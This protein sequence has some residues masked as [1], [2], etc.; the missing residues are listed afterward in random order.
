MR[1]LCGQLS[2][3]VPRW[4]SRREN[5]FSQAAAGNLDKLLASPSLWMCV[6]CYACSKRCPR[7]IELTEGL[8]PALRDAAMQQGFQPPA[9]LQETFQNVLK[10][11]NVLGKSPRQRL[12]WA[13]NLDVRVLDLS[14]EA[15]AGRRAVAGGLLPVVLSRNQVVARAFARI[16]TELG[17]TWGILGTKEKAV[18]ECDRM[19][20]EEGLFETLV[21]EN[22]KLFDK[23]DFGKLV[24]LDPH[25]YRALQSFYPRF[26]HWYPVQH[27]TM[28]L[29]EYL[30]QLRP[31]MVK[32]V[33]AVVTYHDNCCVGRRCGCY[34][35]PRSL[36]GLIPGVK[37]VEMARNRDD[38]LCC[39]G[40][41]GGMWL[42]AHIVAHGGQ[43][44][45]DQRIRQA[46][47]SG[48]DTLAVSCPY[49]LSRFEDAAKVTGLEGQI[50]V[51]D[52]IE[53]LAE[54]MDLGE[55][56]HFMNIVV[57]VRQ[58]PDLIEP[59]EVAP[60]GTELDLGAA[61]FILNESDDHALEQALLLKEA[62]GG[63]VTVVALDFGEVDNTL[64]TAA[65][66]GADRIVKIV[67]DGETPS[68]PRSRGG[69][70]AE[71]IKPL[72]ADLV[73]VGVQAH[74]EL[75]GGLSPF[76]AV[77]LG[78]PYVGVIRGVKAGPEAGTVIA[79]KEFPG[80]VMARM[81]VKL[82]AVLGILARISPRVT[83]R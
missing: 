37:L 58:V 62:H 46:A 71:A 14:R 1:P 34:D 38:S 25:A 20:G 49:E 3:W 52:I 77:A 66:K 19:F 13:K 29:A 60:S 76:L 68:P 11:G 35:P 78:L 61:S 33:E 22:R 28:F 21:E 45:S 40:G 81:K 24:V 44:L 72:G 36:L 65:A 64:Y 56:R 80:A 73:L 59:L 9:E 16:L 48:A 75:D 15:P 6:A 30:E 18:G 8:W 31:L 70:Y 69:P 79:C 57:V 43:R 53:L 82:P 83:S 23:Y 2:L 47:D 74:D 54:S 42:D 10:Y 12:D 17:I 39:G 32:P 27:Y 63:S 67:P 41:G 55:R 50:K 26:G 51:R 4:S 5:C 7:G